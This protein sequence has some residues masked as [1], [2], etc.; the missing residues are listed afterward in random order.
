MKLRDTH[1]SVYFLAWTFGLTAAGAAVGALLFLLGGLAIG[2]KFT[3]VELLS[4]GAGKV[5]YITFVWAMPI[6]IMA[7]VIRGYRRK[8]PEA[9]PVARRPDAEA[10]MKHAD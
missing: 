1:W 5:G 7:C 10:G 8:H 2:A 6:A 9:A 4:H 3:P